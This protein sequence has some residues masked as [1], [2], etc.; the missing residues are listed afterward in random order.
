MA[1]LRPEIRFDVSGWEFEN[2]RLDAYA[3]PGGYPIIY[4]LEDRQGTDELCPEC[5]QGFV[6]GEPPFALDPGCVSA[7]HREINWE[8][9]DLQCAH[10][11]EHLECAYPPDDEDEDGPE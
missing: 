2:H 8:D 9:N 6:F 7:L 4:L 5:A 10:C 11:G 3:W 1:H